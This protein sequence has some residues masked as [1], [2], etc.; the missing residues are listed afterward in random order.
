MTGAEKKRWQE[1]G[2]GAAAA[3][4]VFLVVWKLLARGDVFGGDELVMLGERG[5]YGSAGGSFLVAL[6]TFLAFVG[7]HV[8]DLWQSRQSASRARTSGPTGIDMEVDPIAGTCAAMIAHLKAGD[9]EAATS[10]FESL[11]SLVSRSQPP[12]ARPPKEA[13]K[14]GVS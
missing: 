10:A 8:I 1:I 3:A 6:L 5:T 13:K 12:S 4:L 14:G 9:T 2:V 11:E 7:R